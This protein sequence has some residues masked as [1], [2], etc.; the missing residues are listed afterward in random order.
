MDRRA[1]FSTTAAGLAA[2]GLASGQT[3]ARKGRLKQ[4]A[5]LG[6]FDPRKT[7][8]T[9]DDMCREAVRLGLK[10]LEIVPIKDWPTLKKYGL[11]PT[12]CPSGFGP[13][14]SP[15]AFAALLAGAGFTGVT[16]RLSASGA[17]CTGAPMK[18]QP[19]TT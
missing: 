16:A 18:S 1:F 12:L 2:A 7:G 3:K 9:L 10:G 15:D 8:M 19:T 14:S 17:D 6:C 11:V 5:I 13:H 4:S